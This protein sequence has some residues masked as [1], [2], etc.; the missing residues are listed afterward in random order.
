VSRAFLETVGLMAEDY[1][2][3]FEELDWAERARHR[4]TLGYASKSLVRHK[5]GASIG[6]HDF[7]KSSPLSVHFMTRNRVRFCWRF[8]KAA[9]P[10][11]AADLIYQMA[12][13]GLR[14]DWRRVQL[15]A[16]AALQ[17]P[18]TTPATPEHRRSLDKGAGGSTD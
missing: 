5:V 6:T 18:F 4:F 1:F 14:G 10:Y 17:R 15:L 13:A 9:L 12:R 2:L 3:Y 16:A 11:V 8:R 7:G